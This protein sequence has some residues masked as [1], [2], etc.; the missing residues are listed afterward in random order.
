MSDYSRD[1]S[2]YPDPDQPPYLVSLYGPLFYI[3]LSL[4]L[5]LANHNIDTARML[6]RITVAGF[7]VAGL[8]LVFLI[9]YRISDSRKKG[10]VAILLACAPH[11]IAHWTTQVRGDLLGITFSLLS[12]Y[13]VLAAPNY[14]NLAA[15]GVCSVLALLCKQTFVAAPVAVLV[16]LLWRRRFSYALIGCAVVGLGTLL[17]YGIVM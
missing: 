10:A 5:R 14:R 13:F 1:G 2:I 8:F 9:V 11:V 4:P 7:W 6:V 3:L 16:Y 12:I 17:G 15:G